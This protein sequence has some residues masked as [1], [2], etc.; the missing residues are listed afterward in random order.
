MLPKKL[1]F[2]VISLIALTNR[3][4][5]FMVDFPAKLLKVNLYLTSLKW[6]EPPGFW[7]FNH[8]TSTDFQATSKLVCQMVSQIASRYFS[9]FPWKTNYLSFFF[10]WKN[11]RPSHRGFGE[12]SKRST[13]DFRW[14]ESLGVVAGFDGLTSTSRWWQLQHFFVFTPGE[15]IQFDY[16]I[17]QLGGST[18][19]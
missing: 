6:D 4:A 14:S 11:L 1:L 17:F 12:S 3:I 5:S 10:L 15:M 16:N 9:D 8:A 7:E 2:L 19:N 18:T 13:G